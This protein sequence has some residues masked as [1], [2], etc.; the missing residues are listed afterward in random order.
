[1]EN[2]KEVSVPLHCVE[3]VT[4]LIPEG[5]KEKILKLEKQ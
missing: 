1:M 3:D 2:K 5:F 4:P